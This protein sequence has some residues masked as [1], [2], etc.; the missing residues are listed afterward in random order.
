MLL[1]DRRE[2][3]E[4]P[5]IPSKIDIP[6]II[7]TLYAGDYA[8]L[9]ARQEPLGIERCEIGNYIQKL[10]SGE[11]ES[12]MN[13]CDESYMSIIL[14]IEGVFDS[15]DGFLATYRLGRRGYFRTHI[16]PHTRFESVM[17]SLIRMSELGI[18]V[19]F[20]PNF[21]S[22]LDLVKAIYVQRTKPEEEHSLFKRVRAIKI[23]VKL[24]NNPSV[25]RLMALCPR[26]P[27]KTAIRLINRFDTIWN[28]LNTSDEEILK[29]EGMGK[30]LLT[31]LKGG[32]GK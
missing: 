25:P 1:I 11:L 3:Q 31:T 21:D 14:L 16:Y 8:F 15:V 9:D 23:P 28:V 17:S 2:V 20:S 7:D 30:G 18:E 19:I 29:V 10:R 32:V 26:L 27:E 6:H 13:R 12:Q 22:T 5:D 4:H 24:T